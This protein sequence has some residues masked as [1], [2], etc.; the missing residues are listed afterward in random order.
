MRPVTPFMIRPRRWVVIWRLAPLLCVFPEIN[1]LD[2]YCPA[3]FVAWYSA[4]SRSSCPGLPPP[5]KLRRPREFVAR[6]SLGGDGTRASTSWPS[7]RKGVDGR[8]KP[9]YDA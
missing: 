8:V 6:R 1:L 4:L 5:L 2:K 7:A 9:G 3:A